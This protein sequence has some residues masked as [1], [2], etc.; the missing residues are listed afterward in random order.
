MRKAGNLLLC[1]LCILAGFSCIDPDDFDSD[2]FADN[3]LSYDIAIPLAYNRLTI[4]NLIDLK[5]GLFIPDDTGLLHIIYTT[6][7]VTARLIG[8]IHIGNTAPFGIDIPQTPYFCKDT[9]YTVPFTDTL[10]L[11]L[12]NLPAEDIKSAYLSSVKISLST[13]NTFIFPAEIKLLLDNMKDAQG[14]AIAINRQSAAAINSDTS[15]ILHDVKVEMQEGKAPYIALSGSATIKTKSMPGDTLLRYGAFKMNFQMSDMEFQRIDGHLNT[16]PFEIIGQLPIAGFGLERMTDLK[17]E[18]ADIIADLRVKGIS[19]PIRLEKTSL[20]LNNHNEQTSLSLF[21]DNFDVPYPAIDQDSLVAESRKSTDINNLLID[22]P[23]SVSYHLEGKMNPD[24]DHTSLQAIEKDGN[25]SMKLTCDV[26]LQFSASRYA[27]TDTINFSIDDI[28]ESTT[29]DFFEIKTILK[30]AFPLEMTL[31]LHFLDASRNEL[32]TLFDDRILE[33]GRIGPAPG[34]HVEEAIVS[35]FENQL[36]ADQLELAKKIKYVILNAVINTTD[37]QRVNVYMY[38]EN[39]SY[40]DVKIGT[41]FK[42][43]Q[44]GLLG[45]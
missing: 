3:G 11:S 29:F 35:T 14:K 28:D 30:N 20:L 45:D 15:A 26:P 43:T 6:E 18:R 10:E 24:L 16:V 39:E 37:C 4:E 9:V 13:A 33:G 7:P 21:P 34:Y 42:I 12:E 31:C 19:A 1:A 22:R 36:N 32:F 44:K 40:L 23:S 25:I 38:N 41:R 2:R 5:G 8:D 27:L 17:F